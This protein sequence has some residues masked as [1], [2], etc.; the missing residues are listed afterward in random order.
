MSDN[1]TPNSRREKRKLKGNWS[2]SGSIEIPRQNEHSSRH[3]KSGVKKEMSLACSSFW[4]ETEEV[5][6][7]FKMVD[8]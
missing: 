3:P 4:L 1:A 5:A 7:K 8:N 2:E 6:F